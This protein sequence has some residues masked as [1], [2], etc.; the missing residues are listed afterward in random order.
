MGNAIEK[1]M[2]RAKEMAGRVTGDKKLEFRGKLEHD[3][4]HLKQ[5]AKGTEEDIESR[6]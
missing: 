5:H 6:L 1:L 3:I 2:G 4:A